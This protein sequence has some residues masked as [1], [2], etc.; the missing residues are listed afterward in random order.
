MSIIERALKK[1]QESREQEFVK[2]VGRISSFPQAQPIQAPVSLASPTVSVQPVPAAPRS[3][4]ILNIDREALRTGGVLPPPDQERQL[5]HEY[6]QIKRP[7]IATAF[8]RG[9]PA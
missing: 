3:G 7:L 4:R 1:I 9:K 6:R 5:A 2:P 8:G